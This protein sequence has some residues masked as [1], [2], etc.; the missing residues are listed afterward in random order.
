VAQGVVARLAAKRG[1]LNT[2]RALA[3]AG[4]VFSALSFLASIAFVYIS[5]D[6]YKNYLSKNNADDQGCYFCGSPDRYYT[7]IALPTIC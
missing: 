1:R 7:I 2:V 6:D 4:A 5:Q 3:T